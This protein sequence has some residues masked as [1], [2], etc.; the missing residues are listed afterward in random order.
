[1]NSKRNATAL[2]ETWLS[3]SLSF[4][5][6]ISIKRYKRRGVCE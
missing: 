2:A 1:M 6:S 5:Y 3:F 4:S